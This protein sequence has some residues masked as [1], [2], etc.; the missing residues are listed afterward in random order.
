LKDITFFFYS[1]TKVVI[2][3]AKKR[4]KND[5]SNLIKNV[6]NKLFH[7]EKTTF[8]AMPSSMVFVPRADS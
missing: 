4:K 6:K 2:Y 1:K 8:L 7:G 3:H 5:K